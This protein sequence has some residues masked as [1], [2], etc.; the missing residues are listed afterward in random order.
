[1]KKLLK[2][3]FG[4]KASENRK[5]GE[6]NA[7]QEKNHHHSIPSKQISERFGR[8]IERLADK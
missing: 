4:F 1:M 2:R 6:I 5:Q 7:L 3:L 8:A